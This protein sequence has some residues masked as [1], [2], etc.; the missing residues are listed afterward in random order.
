MYLD[1]EDD[2]FTR[3]A[4]TNMKLYSH[5]LAKQ[6]ITLEVED[7]IVPIPGTQLTRQFRDY[8]N[9]LS[10]IYEGRCYA[11]WTRC[12]ASQRQF[13]VRNARLGTS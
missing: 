8:D 9:S 12:E 5:Y 3:S 11:Y 10:L 7:Q 2:E 13:W 4:E 6:T 1:F